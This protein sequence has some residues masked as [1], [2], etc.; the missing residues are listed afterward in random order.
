MQ[1]HMEYVKREL[2]SGHFHENEWENAPQARIPPDNQS[3]PDSFWQTY[4]KKTGTQSIANLF[5]LPDHASDEAK[6]EIGWVDL[7]Q[8]PLGFDVGGE[9]DQ[10]QARWRLRMLKEV[11]TWKVHESFS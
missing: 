7:G 11:S 1:K 10:D 8:V 9:G 5:P 2:D 3:S 4:L 6:R